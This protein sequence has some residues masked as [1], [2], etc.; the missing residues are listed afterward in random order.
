MSYEL[1]APVKLPK[2]TRTGARLYVVCRWPSFTLFATVRAGELVRPAGPSDL[3]AGRR[4][5]TACVEFIRLA[6]RIGQSTS[7]QLH[8]EARERD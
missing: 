8:G 1:T 5:V 6:E 2:G 3:A 7:A 4:F